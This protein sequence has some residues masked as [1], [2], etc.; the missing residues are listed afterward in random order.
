MMYED[1]TSYI[2]GRF[3]TDEAIADFN[4]SLYQNNWKDI[5]ECENYHFT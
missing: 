1:E 3:L 2:Y 5:L 4:V